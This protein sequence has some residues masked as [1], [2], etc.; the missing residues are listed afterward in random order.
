M[1]RLSVFL[2]VTLVLVLLAIQDTASVSR[3]TDSSYNWPSS[4]RV[5]CTFGFFFL[6]IQKKMSIEEAKKTI[7]NL[8]KV[9]SKKN[10]TPKGIILFSD[11]CF[12]ELEIR[13]VPSDRCCNYPAFRFYEISSSSWKFRIRRFATVTLDD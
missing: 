13:I 6:H 2:L 4:V 7:K 8:R 1:K 12:K 3:S 5:P 10:D 9:C 11:G